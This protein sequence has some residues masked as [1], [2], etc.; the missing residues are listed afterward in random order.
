MI[1]IPRIDRS[2]YEWGWFM[3]GE[4][5]TDP[6]TGSSLTRPIGLALNSAFFAP[7]FY[8]RA[9]LPS[10]GDH[11]LG[12]HGVLLQAWVDHR[13]KP[14]GHPEILG[15]MQITGPV[16]QTCPENESQKTAGLMFLATSKGDPLQ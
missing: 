15:Q 2:I 6:E 12:S 4:S 9:W 1:E 14:L 3:A 8:H 16:V 5:H 7:I 10:C 11:N 13:R